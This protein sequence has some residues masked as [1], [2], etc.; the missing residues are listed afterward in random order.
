[1]KQKQRAAL[2]R[3]ASNRRYRHWWEKPWFVHHPARK[4]DGVVRCA[5]CADAYHTRQGKYICLTCRKV[6]RNRGKEPLGK[7][8][9]CAGSVV[10]VSRYSRVPRARNDK[11]WARLA[12]RFGDAP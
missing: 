3:V 10:Q 4:R 12:K 1:M 9:Q 5:G 11:A 7:C 2:Q 6:W 8:P